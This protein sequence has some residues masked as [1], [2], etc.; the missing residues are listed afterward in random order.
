MSAETYT[1]VEE[2]IRAH[3]HD[4]QRVYLTDWRLIAAAVGDDPQSTYY[5]HIG[6]DSGLHVHLGL[7]EF[8]RQRLLADYH[9][10]TR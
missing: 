7:L 10:D 5:Q 1:A 4:E 8:G 9:D 6:S 3:L 2:A